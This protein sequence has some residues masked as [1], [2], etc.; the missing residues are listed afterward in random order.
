VYYPDARSEPMASQAGQVP[1]SH[2]SFF[3]ALVYKL[4]NVVRV[5]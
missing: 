1:Y 3:T 5:Y 2:Y 4:L